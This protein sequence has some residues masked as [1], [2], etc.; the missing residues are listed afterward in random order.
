[1]P[2][3]LLLP[4]G[5]ASRG[6]PIRRWFTRTFSGRAIAAGAIVKV[7][8]FVL[9]LLGGPSAV[10]EVVDTI[11]DVAL[12]A[13]AIAL[14]FR[15]F[16][17]AKHLLLWR[18]R[19][20][21]TVSY[22]FIGFVPAL[23][24]IV[25]FLVCGLLLFF[26][27]A[28][29]LTQDELAGLVGQAQFIAESTALGVQRARTAEDVR[30]M[31]A[32][33]Q[34]SAAG[35]YDGASLALVPASRT[36]GTGT[37]VGS[38]PPVPIS[39]GAWAHLRAPATVPSWI[40]CSGYAGLVTYDD[41]GLTRV[42]ARAAVWPDGA[43]HAVVVDIPAG[44]P[45]VRQLRDK[46]G[47]TL[48]DIGTDD[49]ADAQGGSGQGAIT[50]DAGEPLG[51]LTFVESAQWDSGKALTLYV[52]FRTSLRAIYERISFSPAT[53]VGGLGPGEALLAVLAGVGVL[54]LIIQAVAFGMG[55][56]LA[57][58]ITGSVHELFAGTERI[59]RGDFTGKIAIR[60][61]DQLGELAESFNSMTSSIEELL[62]Q[63]AEKERLEQ[64]L[65]IARNI[66]MS[67]LPQGPLSMPGLSVAAHCEPAREVGGDYYD[68]LPI[69]E[70]R[71]GILV[72][73][74]SGKGT[75]AA[76]YM[77]ELKGIVLSLS[78]RHASPRELLIEADRIISRHL[79]SRSF[80][81]VTYILVDLRA[82]VLS[83]ARAG[84]CP[85][86]YVPGNGDGPRV[87]QLIA[88][89]GLVLGLQLDGG[90]TFTRLLE[91]VNLPLGPGDLFLLYTDGMSEAMNPEGDCFGDARLADLVGTHAH[92]AQD[93]LRERILREIA[94][95][96][97]PA[98]Q[99]DDMT[100][101]LLRVDAVGASL[102]A[103]A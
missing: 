14:G 82:A 77:A 74:V 13:G 23:L 69:D 43:S 102:G 90:A 29:Y 94:G 70:H 33:R 51:W 49:T 15:L 44:D 56:A 40:P 24:I 22:I 66:Q 42:A 45:F 86:I 36:C 67:L 57:R 76:L 93:E 12:I 98:P 41:G 48:G 4:P 9:R 101:V 79:D 21:L 52:T 85:M 17:D 99:H 100:M 64:E 2:R 58:S 80:I 65:R 87:P 20:K 68:F 7:A 16:V 59:R 91:E 54:F 37:P 96:A 3:D 84:H 78:Q 81:T 95:F 73:D 38:L 83:Y 11:G 46:V 63:K 88:P 10:V 30:E 35:R 27:I 8:A 28:S 53:V 19:R 61:R 18:V 62:L 32:R 34:E 60:S 5:P 71:V 103:S 72:A 26:N 50:T 89:N 75:S 6:E 1:V 31:L 39:L 55:L 25:F 97:G 47:I 92:L